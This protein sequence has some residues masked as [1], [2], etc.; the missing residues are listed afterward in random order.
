MHNTKINVIINGSSGKMGKEAMN[1]VSK[2][3]ELNLVA[4]LNRTDNLAA[5]IK[6][7]NTKDNPVVVVDLTSSECVFE[8]AKTIIT[9]N[10]CPVIG[11]SGLL[12]SDTKDLQQLASDYKVN[13]I[14]VPNFSLGAVLMMHFSSIAAK[15]YDQV[16]I[17]ERHHSDKLDSPSGTALRTADLIAKNLLPHAS[18]DKKRHETVAQARGANYKNIP[19]H[20]IRL[21]GSCGHQS[22]MFGGADEGL[23]ISHDSLHRASFMPGVIL[24]C[25]K[26]NTQNGLVVGLEHL[27]NI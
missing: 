18:N 21:N 15:F 16:E 17:I 23:T 13:G 11:S 1:A 26:A 27:L 3:A 10:A 20:S 14:I 12:E 22:V 9:H 25:K 19:I 7:Y 2:D 24:A 4:G 6:K 8:N 5:A